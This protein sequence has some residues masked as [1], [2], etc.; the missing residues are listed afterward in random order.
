MAVIIIHKI[1]QKSQPRAAA[2][3]ESTSKSIHGE[4]GTGYESPNGK[5]DFDCDNCSFFE[6][7]SVSCGQEDMM[8]LSKRPRLPSGRVV[9]HPEGCCEFV[10]RVGNDEADDD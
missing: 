10:D 1:E 9:V 6:E 5:G 7:E 3:P 2:L 8:K 4:E